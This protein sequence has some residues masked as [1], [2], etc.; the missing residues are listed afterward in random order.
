ME[1]K[2]PTAVLDFQHDLSLELGADTIASSAWTLDSGITK[3]SDSYTTTASTIW[4]SDGTAGKTY[5][6]S[7]TI[8]TAAGRTHY[9]AFY[10]R[11]QEQRA[12]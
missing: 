5:A 4:I 1:F 6:V 7:N 2:S 11:V 10:L 3:D 9:K 12:G 8:T